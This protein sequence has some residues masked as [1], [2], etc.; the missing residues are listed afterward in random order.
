M[1]YHYYF[2]TKD[3]MKFG[4]VEE[5]VARYSAAVRLI[6]KTSTLRVR[7]VIH[8]SYSQSICGASSRNL[9]V[10]RKLMTLSK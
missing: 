3:N 6:P 4:H 5:F 10:F 1:H 8:E 2:R 9:H 7:K